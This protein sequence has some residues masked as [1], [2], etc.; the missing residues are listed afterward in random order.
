VEELTIAE[1]ALR[2]NVSLGALNAIIEEGDVCVDAEAVTVFLDPT[3]PSAAKVMREDQF[4]RLQ[5]VAQ[6]V[7]PRPIP[8]TIAGCRIL[9]VIA[10]GGMGI[11]Y[12]ALQP[13]VN[14]HVAIKVLKHVT[15]CDEAA[16][17]Q[18][19]TEA[20]AAGRLQH[21]GI[22]RIYS[23][24]QE[25]WTHYIIMELVEGKTLETFLGD[26]LL[27]NQRTAQI[28]LSLAETMSFA[29]DHGV[30]HRDLKRTNILMDTDE[31][32]RIADFGLARLEDGDAGMTA[33]G[34]IFGTPLYMSPEQ[35][36]G[37]RKAITASVDIWAIGIIIY[38]CIVGRSPFHAVGGSTQVMECVLKTDPTPL[39][40]LNRDVDPDLETICLACLQK[41][42]GD[43]PASAGFLAEELRRFLNHE[44]IQLRRVSRYQQ[45]LRWCRRHPRVAMMRGALAALVLMVLSGIPLLLWQASLIAFADQQQLFGERTI[46][47]I[48]LREE[49]QQE[50]A[51]QADANAREHAH[52][53]AVQK[54]YATTMEAG[55]VRTAKEPS[56]TWKVIN[57]VQG[58]AGT[59]LGEI[60]DVRLRSLAADALTSID[61]LKVQTFC[62]GLRIDSMGISLDGGTL[63]LPEVRGNPT[64]NVHLLSFVPSGS[65]DPLTPFQMSPSRLLSMNTDHLGFM[66][67][68]FSKD[69]RYCATGA[70]DGTLTL[71]DLTTVVPTRIYQKEFEQKELDQ[72]LFSPDEQ[73]LFIRHRIVRR[74]RKL[75]RETGAELA[76]SGR[77]ATSMI[78]LPNGSL[79]LAEENGD[80][81]ADS[82]SL[83][84]VGGSSVQ[85]M[86]QA[87]RPGESQV[88]TAHHGENI[89]VFDAR[90]LLPGISM[91]RI[92]YSGTWVYSHQSLPDAGTVIGTIDPS[93]VRIRDGLSGR[94]V[95]DLLAAGSSVSYI[96]ID[97][98]SNRL[99]RMTGGVGTAFQVR[100]PGSRS[101]GVPATKSDS[102][103]MDFIAPGGTASRFI[104]LESSR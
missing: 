54:Y 11:V 95:T 70:Q 96:C 16:V 31:C 39:H 36:A 77:D 7:D 14:R 71:W 98:R 65:A 82:E 46:S 12:R 17:R 58:A 72:I 34:Q 48:R 83:S 57:L 44:P 49:L 102:A 60:D 9:N 89:K 73:Q 37:D 6:G 62:E 93:I 63:A 69:G 43:R 84:P 30:I 27:D 56:W 88:F 97:E 24:G 19:Q 75:D 85:S 13:G 91:Q 2:G 41:S 22:V 90:T 92:A 45:M 32:P 40:L 33:P 25:N 55:E 104:Q 47:E 18:F 64:A 86:W 21:P 15:S 103:I 35:I 28:A 26:S 5:I 59:Q 42:P 3:S 101:D 78:I 38:R 100:A 1:Y 81:V 67:A 68:A 66:S 23:A 53:A 29:H 50:R 74:V 10:A 8:E 20:K 79:L 61:V 4:T 52:A 80:V 76:S 99:F 94:H 87:Y 51:D